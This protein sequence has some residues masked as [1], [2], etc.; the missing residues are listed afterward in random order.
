MSDYRDDK[1]LIDTYCNGAGEEFKKIM[2]RYFIPSPRRECELL[3]Q[4]RMQDFWNQDKGRCAYY[5]FFS[6]EDAVMNTLS[7]FYPGL[8]I[9]DTVEYDR[10]K[11]IIRLSK[12]HPLKKGST[13]PVWWR[14][15]S[16]SV[17]KEIG[18]AYGVVPEKK[19]CGTC[20]HLSQTTDYICLKKKVIRPEGSEICKQYNPKPTASQKPMKQTCPGCAYI[21]RKTY[22]CYKKQE[23]RGRETLSCGDE[24]YCLYLPAA[25]LSFDDEAS[26][27]GGEN[28]QRRDWLLSK[29]R[30]AEKSKHQKTPEERLIETEEP[31]Q[32]SDKI[33]S[34][35]RT[36]IEQE[37]LSFQERKKCALYH[38]IVTNYRHLAR[39][40]VHRRHWN[41][42]VAEMLRVT[43][44]TIGKYKKNM[45]TFLRRHCMS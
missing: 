36:H 7:V 5:I 4:Q 45:I 19:K 30:I 24:D 25:I 40:G 39:K 8:S 28:H 34:C 15:V 32:W 38:D 14:Y 42:R 27:G 13:L 1:S 41:T 12:P 21:S 10:R 22:F 26:S 44:Q 3:L 17:Y 35:L 33:L 11:V 43:P 2:C 16:K 37:S 29:R 31:Q 6:A 23:P 20:Q 18:K 9:V